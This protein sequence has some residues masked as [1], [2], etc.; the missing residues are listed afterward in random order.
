MEKNF[1][2]RCYKILCRVPR[3]RVTTY[4]ELAHAL[5]SKA[6]RAVGNAMHHNPNAPKVPCHR[7]VTSSGGLGGYQGGLPKKIKILASEGVKVSG[8]KIVD[9]D[10]R[11][12]PLATR[13]KQVR[14]QTA[15]K[16]K[17]R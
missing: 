4:R 14:K 17:S 12:Y 10:K 5:G 6:Y 7:V 13:S 3:G 1:S 15:T 16:H 2:E 9:F 8:G 11:F